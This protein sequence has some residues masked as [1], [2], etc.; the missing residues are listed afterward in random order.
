MPATE[1]LASN[2]ALPAPP[3]LQSKPT[4]NG[5]APNGASDRLQIINNEKEFTCVYDQVLCHLVLRRLSAGPA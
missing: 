1:V 5:H 3:P 4:L 2:V